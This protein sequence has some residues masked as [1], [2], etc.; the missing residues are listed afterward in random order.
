MACGCLRGSPP[1][2][3]APTGS[4]KSG[5]LNAPRRPIVDAGGAPAWERPLFRIN[6]SSPGRGCGAT[7]AEH[8]LSDE[9]TFLLATLP[10]TSGQRRLALAVVAA[11]VVYFAVATAIGLTAPFA[12]VPMPVDAFIP[13]LSAVLFMNDAVTATLLFSQYSISRLPALLMLANGY[14]FTALII[15]PFA[16]TYPGAFS[17]TG[18]LGSASQSA[19][20]LF[21]FWHDGFPLAVLS[22]TWLKD[23]SCT[24]IGTSGS[25]RATIGWNVATVIFLA[26]GLTLLATAGGEY[27]PRLFV[28]RITPTPLSRYNVLFTVLVCFLALAVLWSRRRSLLDQWIIVVM[29]AWIVELSMVVIFNADRFTFAFYATRMASLFT[30]AIVLVVLLAETTRL[31]GRLARSNLALQRERANKLMNL[32]V[33]AASIAHEVRQPL[34]SV[35]TNGT[36]ALR[37]LGHAPPDLEEVRSALDR[38]VTNSHRAGEIFDNLRALFGNADQRQEPIDVNEIVLRALRILRGELEDHGV[39]ARTE[40]TP[41]LP[42]VMGH[43]GQ[44]EEVVLNLARNA[45]EAMDAVRD[46]SRELRVAT[47]HR[48]RQAIIVAVDDTGPGIDP[49]QADGIFD[50]FVTTK[51]HGMGLGLAICRM[52]VERHGGKISAWPDKKS[53]GASFEVVLPIEPA[54]ASA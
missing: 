44:L 25:V 49:K 10:P 8:K 40:L 15:I 9:P 2:H 38:I 14:F 19:P 35:A 39:T 12:D 23:D 42:L 34:T 24:S 43:G 3:H 50:A 20:W 32:E 22:Y 53:G 7:L 27:L 33:M 18:L 31:Y 48:D 1:P 17:A 45:I 6:R 36:A 11:L 26:A 41:Q 4:L 52:V 47:R 13:T 37:W 54:A 51:P 5:L 30:S 16:L 46:G 29:S 21:T 28:D